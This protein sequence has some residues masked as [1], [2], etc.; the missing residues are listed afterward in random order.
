GNLYSP[1]W[2]RYTVRCPVAG[3]WLRLHY[4]IIIN[5]LI[6]YII[7]S[8]WIYRSLRNGFVYFSYIIPPISRGYRYFVP[9]G[10]DTYF[11]L[12]TS[13][14]LFPTSCFLQQHLQ[15]F[16][17]DH[18][19]GAVFVPFGY[20]YPGRTKMYEVGGGHGF[21]FLILISI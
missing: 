10:Q 17:R 4:P 15:L 8:S 16:A 21:V 9:T 13:Y 5:Q 11:L 2:N 18:K 14:F 1:G 3:R 12:L 7:A 6:F 19:H 20:R